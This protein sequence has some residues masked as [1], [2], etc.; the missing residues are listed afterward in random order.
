MYSVPIADGHNYFKHGF[1]QCI[2]NITPRL[3]DQWFLKQT[4]YIVNLIFRIAV[5]IGEVW[6]FGD[7]FPDRQVY[8]SLNTDK[9]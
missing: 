9:T 8:I 4:Q 1:Q 5:F 3:N 2:M 7:S 6:R